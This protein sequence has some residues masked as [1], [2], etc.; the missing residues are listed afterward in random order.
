MRTKKALL[1]SSINMIGFMIAFI[2]NIIV[3]KM[4]LEILGSELLGLNSLYANIIGWLSIA[5]LGIGNVI[6]F[7]LYKPYAMN[8]KKLVRAYIK[9][10][11]S[12]YRTIGIIILGIGF[13][14]TPF[15]KFFI[16][17][18]IDLK[19]VSLGFILLLMNSFIS[20]IFQ[21]EYVY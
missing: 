6:V 16:E 17:S 9:F 7:S 21:V 20:Y 13:C 19:L 12:F 2:P 4:F 10:Y 1:N 15:L 11:K 8:D 14:L 5:E 18:N 3:R